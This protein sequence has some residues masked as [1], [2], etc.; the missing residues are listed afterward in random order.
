MW[1]CSASGSLMIS[2]S[3]DGPPAFDLHFYLNPGFAH[4]QHLQNQHIG[5]V[6]NPLR[7]QLTGR[8]GGTTGMAPDCADT[9]VSKS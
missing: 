5:A 7:M 9:V 2:R 8:H 1:T 6:H 4:L 3:S